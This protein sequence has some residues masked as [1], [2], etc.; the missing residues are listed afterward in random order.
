[1]V[2]V[3]EV[4]VNGLAAHDLR[5]N[6]HAFQKAVWI[7]LKIGP[8]LEGAGLALVDVHG[9]QARRRLLAHDAPLAPGRKARAA[10]PA[11]SG[12]FHGVNDGL[13]VGAAAAGQHGR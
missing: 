5:G 2:F 6:Q 3:A 9:H 12:I 13:D 10:Q 8:V 1:M 7:A 4:D 11:Q